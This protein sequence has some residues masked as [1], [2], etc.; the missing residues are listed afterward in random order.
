MCAILRKEEDELVLSGY[1][2]RDIWVYMSHTT[3]LEND[4]IL[5][6]GVQYYK[7]EIE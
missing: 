5:K 7:V 3:K 2:G 6:C 4:M 1:G